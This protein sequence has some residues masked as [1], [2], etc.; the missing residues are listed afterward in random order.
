MDSASGADRHR[1][2][3]GLA[4]THVLGGLN[5]TE[6]EVFRS[7][8]LE[9]PSCRARVGELRRIAND[10]ADVERDERR[11]R[12][13]KAIE[14]K[15][16]EADDEEDDLDEPPPGPRTS[17]I[18]LLLGLLAIV[19]LAGWNFFLRANLDQQTT[20]VE[21]LEITRDLL[22]DGKIAVYESPTGQLEGRTQVRYDDDYVLLVLDGLAGDERLAVYQV[23]APG[24][25]V[26]TGVQP[27]NGDRL[28]L[29]VRR[30]QN[31]SRL[32]VTRPREDEQL[33]PAEVQGVTVLN[34][35]LS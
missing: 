28:T 30:A 4:V 11:V 26:E 13:T 33:S 34:A 17:R 27:V 5:G 18:L 19:G 10:L 1:Y 32:I 31:V 12:A 3:E 29:L 15:R 2:Y 35:L 25:V 20:N 14:T 7:H 8:L 21:G 22:L 23:N 9:C 24:G 6:S 16:R